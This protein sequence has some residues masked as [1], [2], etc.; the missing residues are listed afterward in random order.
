MRVIAFV[1]SKGGVGKSTLSACVAVEAVKAGHSVYLLDL[2]PQQSTAT[3]WRRRKGPDNPLLATGVESVSRALRAIRTKKAERDFLIVDTPGSFVG[4]IADAIEEADCV[5]IVVQAS[6]K[7]L[8][9]QGAVE[10]LVTKARKHDKTVYVI[11]RVNPRSALTKAAADAVT[12]KS[13]RLPVTICDRADYVR[14]DAE[15]KTANETTKAAT[16]EIRALWRTLQE[17]ANHE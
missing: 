3:W 8:E 13:I 10:G 17:I 7:D 1:S 4:V 15:G 5:V 6:A 12:A 14:A 9:A 2:D 16:T 11:N